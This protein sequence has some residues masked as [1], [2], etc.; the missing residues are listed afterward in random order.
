MM[1]SK[2]QIM[3]VRRMR[4]PLVDEVRVGR[5]LVLSVMRIV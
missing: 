4:K 1:L 3:L 2:P 5:R